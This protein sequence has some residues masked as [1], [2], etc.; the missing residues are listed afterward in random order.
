MLTKCVE[1]GKLKCDQYWPSDMEPVFYGDLQV[2]IVSEDS[3]C[4][5]WTIR[6]LQISMVYAFCSFL[7]THEA[8]WCIILVV[9]ACVYVC[10]YVC[11]TITFER[12]DVG[13]SFSHARYISTDYWSSSY[14]KVIG[15][16]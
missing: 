3:S 15:S 6:E 11:Q 10:P 8:A 9:S 2:T 16:T 7:T 1:A 4:N 14:M 12:V 5:T 13:I